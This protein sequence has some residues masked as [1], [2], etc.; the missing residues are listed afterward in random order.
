ME[1]S[2]E[3]N[4]DLSNK[5]FYLILNFNYLELNSDNQN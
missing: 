2:N 1:Q 3:E 4:L 5:L